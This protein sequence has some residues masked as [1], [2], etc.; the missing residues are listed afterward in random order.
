MMYPSPEKRFVKANRLTII[1][2][3][4][5]SAAGGI[6]RSTGREMGC[7]EW[8]RSVHRVIPPTDVSKMPEAYEQHYIEGRQKKNE[9]FVNMVEFFGNKEAA[10]KVRHD[11]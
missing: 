1:V 2:L 7:T 9:R 5:V 11:K 8:A 10:D 3:F 4:L 6:V